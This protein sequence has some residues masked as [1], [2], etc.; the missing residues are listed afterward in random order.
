MRR[1]RFRQWLGY[2]L[3]L[4]VE[5]HVSVKLIRWREA[6][7]MLNREQKRLLESTKDKTP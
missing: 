5:P 3:W 1:H 6:G 4:L 7:N 2:R